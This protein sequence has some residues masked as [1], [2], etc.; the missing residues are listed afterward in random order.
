MRIALITCNPFPLGNVSTN[1]F[2]TY[3]KAIAS[4][5]IFLKIL[6]LHPS[7]SDAAKCNAA[8]GEFSNIQY[9]HMAKRAY[10]IPKTSN[11]IKINTFLK[12]LL[13]TIKVLRKDNIDII[14]LYDDKF[15]THLFYKIFSLFNNVS[16]ILEKNEY[17]SNYMLQNNITSYFQNIKYSFFDGF[18]IMTEELI[19]YYSKIKKKT[20]VIFHLPM[21]VDFDRFEKLQKNLV[22]EKYIACTFG[23][24]NRDG[25]IDTLKSYLI[26][27]NK[28]DDIPYKLYIIGDFFNLVKKNE[29]KDYIINNNLVE[30][31]LIKGPYQSDRIPQILKDAECLITTPQKYASGGFPTK[32]GEYLATGNPVIVTNCGE[33]GK[34]L[35]NKKTAFLAEP[36]A[37]GLIAQHLITIHKKPTFSRIIGENGKQFAKY[38]F[39][40][41]TYIDSFILFLCK[42]KKSISD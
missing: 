14:I 16:I 19:N 36:G 2:T 18:I 11:L 38:Y 7:K 22:N 13:R 1:R 31:V 15:I 33:I 41:D 5:G 42:L 28:I 3:C 17:P 24:H 4:K 20:A 6:I 12:A 29:I 10:W 39:N 32:L 35:I 34:Y 25:L 27:K 23:Y 8:N 37:I 30:N 21:T 26:Y 40:A 9:M